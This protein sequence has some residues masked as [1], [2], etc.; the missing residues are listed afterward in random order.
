MSLMKRRYKK[1]IKELFYVYSELE[2]IKE[3]LSEAHSEFEK[4][5]QDYCKKHN[6]PI[7][8]LNRKN[9]EKIE[10]VL[11]KKKVESDQGGIVKKEEPKGREPS[12]N[13]KKIFVKMYRSL[14]SKI[15]P[16][17]FANR[18]TTPEVEEK[19]SY[20]K[21]ATESYGDNNW[22]KFL[23]ICDRFD[24]SPTV[25]ASVNETIANEISEINK[26]IVHKKKMFS[27]RLY[28]CEGNNNC[29]DKII[30]NFLAQLFNYKVQHVIRI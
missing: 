22:S 13:S 2:Y 12:K 14:T 17:K 20:F 11:P 9:A 4:H 5:Y 23:E 18:K 30:E 10:R 1:L 24:I 29:K 21:L 16:D 7:D 6:V 25:Y 19:I 8:E 27:W 15:H 28:E 26:E 3:S